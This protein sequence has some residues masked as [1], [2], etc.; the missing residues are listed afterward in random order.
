MGL[1][2]PSWS[3]PEGTWVKPNDWLITF[4]SSALEQE[5]RQQKIAVNTSEAVM[6]QAKA[7]YDTSVIAKKEYLEGTYKEQEQTIL[8]GLSWRK[9]T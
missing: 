1:R 8:N 3:D 2:P 7:V 4:D 6:I 5:Q 9:R